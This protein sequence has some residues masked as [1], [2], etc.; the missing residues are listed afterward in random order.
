MEVDYFAVDEGV[1]FGAFDEFLE[2]LLAVEKRLLVGLAL[3]LH[4][5]VCVGFVV[6]CSVGAG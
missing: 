4:C 3:D 5:G 1:A 6:Q 2:F